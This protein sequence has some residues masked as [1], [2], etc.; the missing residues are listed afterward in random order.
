M[1]PFDEDPNPVLGFTV[2]GI[3]DLRASVSQPF[4]ALSKSL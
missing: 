4:E 2:M 1:C 3:K